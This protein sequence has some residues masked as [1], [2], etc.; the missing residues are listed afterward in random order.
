[1]KNKK[2]WI[3]VLEVFVALMMIT[4]VALIVVNRDYKEKE[5]FSPK[6]YSIEIGTLRKI[7]LDDFLRKE[8]LEIEE[9]PVELKDFSEILKSEVEAGIPSYLNCDAQICEVNDDCKKELL[10]EED[11]YVQSVI[12]MANSETY[13]PTTLKMFCWVKE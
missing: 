3:R 10:T 6:I 13:K 11:V 2:G 1:M 8:I 4:A 7:Q 9:L 12:L 5:D